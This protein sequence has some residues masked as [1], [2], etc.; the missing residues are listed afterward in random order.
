MGQG[1]WTALAQIAA[2]A[3]GLDVDQV[4]LRSGISTLP[5]GG[6]AGGSGHTASAGLALHN[7]GDDAIARL[8]E[9][10]VADPASPLF[11][12]GNIGVVARNGRLHRRDDERRSESYSD[13]L[14]RARR[15]EVVGTAK[16]A[17]DPAS[18]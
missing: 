5:D 16:A 17:R 6:I 1:A 7:A 18:R 4:E 14:T 13:I 11:G 2:E 9:I 10:A 8:A 3:L 15:G 12:A